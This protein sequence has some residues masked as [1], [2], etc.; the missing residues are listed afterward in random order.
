[1]TLVRDAI[2]THD[3]PIDEKSIE[4]ASINGRR[5]YARFLR[6][7][8]WPIIEE[9]GKTGSYTRTSENESTFRE[10]LHSRAVLQYVNDEEWY[11]LNPMV[12]G[13]RPPSQGIVA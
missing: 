10:L 3:L 7:E 13:L 4:R 8:H 9:I 2:I 1:M 6:A 5:G 11:G 12:A